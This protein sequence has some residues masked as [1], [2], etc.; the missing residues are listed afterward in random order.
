MVW[1]QDFLEALGPEPPVKSLVW[2]IRRRH[3]TISF[4]SWIGIGHAT[5]P[6]P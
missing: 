1:A 5:K 6:T 2:A 3:G 4:Q